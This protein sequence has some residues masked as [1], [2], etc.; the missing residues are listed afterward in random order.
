MPGGDLDELRGFLNAD[1]ESTFHLLVA[2]VTYAFQPAGPFPVLVLQGEQGSAKSTT[3]RV[4]RALIDP[5]QSELRVMPKQEAEL[6]IA[7]K[8]SCV[9]AYDNL[10]G[11]PAWLSDGLC[12]ISTGGTYTARTLYT[13]DEETSIRAKRPVIVNGIDDMTTRPDFADRAIMVSLP[14]IAPDHPSRQTSTD[15]LR[16]ESDRVVTVRAG[17]FGRG[18][19]KRLQ[20]MRRSYRRSGADPVR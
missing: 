3:A 10:S 4:L 8:N 1:L 16:R 17:C 15:Y 2:W 6:M 13:N 7:A 18:G 14:P 20:G 5:S 9:L 19:A 12:I 11:M